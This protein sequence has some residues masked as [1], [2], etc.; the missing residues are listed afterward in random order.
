MD[1][2]QGPP[3]P[4]PPPP[5]PAPPAYMGPPPGHGHAPKKGLPPVAWV[6]IGCGGLIILIAVIAGITAMTVGK[7][8]ME[9]FK[10]HP[11]Q[12]A[13]TALME[14]LPD[15]EKVSEDVEK[16]SI[17]IRAKASGENIATDYD[18]LVLGKTE[19]KDATGAAT[20]IAK[21]DLSKI[22]AWVP[23]YPGA[24]DEKMVVQRDDASQ[25]SGVLV[26]TTNDAAQAVVDSY[27]KAAIPIGFSGNYSGSSEMGSRISKERRYSG[28]G[29]VLR[30]HVHGV[31]GP[32]WIVQVIY[33]GK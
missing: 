26:F 27:E 18:S 12:D 33:E 16:G 32:P 13:V 4:P 17:T 14:K 28:G 21:G 30:V 10:A 19:V 31:S 29:R 11:G 15:Y 3:P 24:I 8:V 5:A 2:T 20:P 6:G 1:Y 9:A 25:T 7:K 22:P 23:R